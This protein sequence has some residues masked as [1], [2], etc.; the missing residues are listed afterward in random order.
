MNLRNI[1]IYIYYIVAIGRGGSQFCAPNNTNTLHRCEILEKQKQNSVQRGTISA[2]L[3]VRSRLV[4]GW[5]ANLNTIGIFESKRQ[6]QPVTIEPASGSKNKQVNSI[7]VAE[8]VFFP[9]GYLNSTNQRYHQ[10]SQATNLFIWPY[11]QYQYFLGIPIFFKQPTLSNNDQLNGEIHSPKKSSLS[12]QLW[13]SRGNTYQKDL[14]A[15]TVNRGNPAIPSWGKGVVYPIIYSVSYIPGGAGFL[16]TTVLSKQMTY[17]LPFFHR[18]SK[19]L[20]TRNQE[21]HFDMIYLSPF[22]NNKIK[23]VRYRSY[24]CNDRTEWHQTQNPGVP[25]KI[26]SMSTGFGIF[27]PIP[28]QRHDHPFWTPNELVPAKT[29]ASAPAFGDW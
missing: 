21:E 26:F 16:A 25:C 6:Q 17:F 28:R 24:K 19:V 13:P 9:K 18:L 27:K 23:P 4:N 10:R 11:M 3:I 2:T 14:M 20:Y 12:C 8:D 7:H 15:T 22:P 1:Y 5:T 29:S